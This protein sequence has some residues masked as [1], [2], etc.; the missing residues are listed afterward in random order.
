M[1]GLTV[2]PRLNEPIVLARLVT[3]MTRIKRADMR[4][5]S[6]TLSFHRHGRPEVSL[7]APFYRQNEARFR[8]NF[9]PLGPLRH[10]R[11]PLP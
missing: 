8:G 6:P 3:L 5:E 7:V 4:A 1:R 11:C 2:L 9:G 10:R